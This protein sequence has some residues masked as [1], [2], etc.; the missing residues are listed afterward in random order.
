VRLCTGACTMYAPGLRH[1]P[2]TQAGPQL[3]LFTQSR[4]HTAVPR[5]AQKRHP[6]SAGPVCSLV[7]RSAIPAAAGRSQPRPV[8]KPRVSVMA[9]ELHTQ[10]LQQTPHAL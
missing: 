1:K 3:E 7:A 10:T 9:S 2:K 4:A 5:Q 6:I 8:V